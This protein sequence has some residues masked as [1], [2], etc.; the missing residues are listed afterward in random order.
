MAEYQRGQ[1]INFLKQNNLQ[2][3][4]S[5]KSAEIAKK[6]SLKIAIAIKKL[7]KNC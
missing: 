6:N 1:Q 2:Q 3:N 4:I 5:L 7:L